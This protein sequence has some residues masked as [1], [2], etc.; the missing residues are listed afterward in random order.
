MRLKKTSTM[1]T[2]F[3]SFPIIAMISMAFKKHKIFWSIICFISILMVNYFSWF[4]KATDYFFHYQAMFTNISKRICPRMAWSFNINIS[5]R[6]FPSTFPIRMF[7]SCIFPFHGFALPFFSF[8]RKFSSSQKMRFS[9]ILKFLKAF[10]HRIRHFFS[11]FYRKFFTFHLMRMIFKII[12]L[13]I[14]HLFS[15][16]WFSH[17]RFNHGYIISCLNYSINAKYGQCHNLNI[18]K[19]GIKCHQPLP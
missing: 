17:I 8:F 5:H 9:F 2:I 13:S 16:F 12:K 3:L 19:G 11:C 4:K 6:N 7:K 14:P 15:N 1:R 10:K 18:F